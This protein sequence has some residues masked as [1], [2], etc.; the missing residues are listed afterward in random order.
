MPLRPTIGDA[1]NQ[2]HERDMLEAQKAEDEYKRQQQIQ[3]RLYKEEEELRM[4]EQEEEE[5]R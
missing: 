3:D 1:P 4:R 5:R 2:A